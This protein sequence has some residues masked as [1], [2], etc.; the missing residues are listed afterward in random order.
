MLFTAFEITVL[1]FPQLILPLLH[2]SQSFLLCSLEKYFL[3]KRKTKQTPICTTFSH[4][5]L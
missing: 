4:S 1:L 5:T 2:P 3:I